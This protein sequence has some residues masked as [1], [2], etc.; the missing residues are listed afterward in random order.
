MLSLP[1]CQIRPVPWTPTK[2]PCVFLFLLRLHSNLF[3][4]IYWLVMIGGLKHL[5]F[6]N[7]FG[8]NKIETNIFLLRVL[9]HQSDRMYLHVFTVDLVFIFW[10]GKPPVSE[11]RRG[12]IFGSGGCCMATAWTTMIKLPER[13]SAEGWSWAD[14]VT[15]CYIQICRSHGSILVNLWM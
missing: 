10:F 13:L 9:H 3:I 12:I 4:Y 11:I 6:S 15:S 2:K 7:L 14:G 5:L 8:I 1:R